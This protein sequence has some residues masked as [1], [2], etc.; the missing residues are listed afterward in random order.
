MSEHEDRALCDSVLADLAGFEVDGD[1]IERLV[2]RLHALHAQRQDLLERLDQSE[3][4]EH[5]LRVE[6]VRA[7]HEFLVVISRA[8]TA[9]NYIETTINTNKAERISDATN[10]PV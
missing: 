4:R 1:K 8:T 5:N 7:R 10:W 2:A 3:Q 9:R 6:L